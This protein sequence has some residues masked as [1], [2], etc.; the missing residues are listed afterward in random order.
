MHVSRS[1]GIAIISLSLGLLRHGVYM[2]S[3]ASHRILYGFFYVCTKHSVSAEGWIARVKYM[4][5]VETV[6]PVASIQPGFHYSQVHYSQ[7]RLHLARHGHET[8]R[9]FQNY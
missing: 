3:R 2:H 4:C 9:D 8:S 6:R 5:V 7:V 1:Q